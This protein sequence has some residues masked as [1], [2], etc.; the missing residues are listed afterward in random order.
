[1]LCEFVERGLERSWPQTETSRL[2]EERGEG[3]SQTGVFVIEEE[4]SRE[5]GEKIR[6]F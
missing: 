2:S 1:L 6:H 4:Q 5:G 3:I